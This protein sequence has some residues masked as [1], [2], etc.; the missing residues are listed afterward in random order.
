MHS[1]LTT[2][3]MIRDKDLRKW[4]RLSAVMMTI[5][6]FFL[7]GVTIYINNLVFSRI[8]PSMHSSRAVEEKMVKRIAD[9]KLR[10]A[11]YASLESNHEIDQSWLKM[12]RAFLILIGIGSLLLFY[13][14]ALSWRS[15]ELAL[16][17]SNPHS[18]CGQVEREIDNPSH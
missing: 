5:L 12:I 16:T 14:A 8:E 18:S 17:A 4:G 6:G 1:T 13:T 11:F 7:I 9:E 15:Y 10:D 3:L 2:I